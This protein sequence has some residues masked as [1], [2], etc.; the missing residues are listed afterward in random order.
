MKLAKFIF[1]F[2]VF[3][4]LILTAFTYFKSRPPKIKSNNTSPT[5]E[6]LSEREKIKYSLETP[7]SESLKGNITSM[8]GEIFWQSRVATE[9][10]KIISPRIILQGENL[11]TGAESSLSLTFEK[12]CV[13]NMEEKTAVEIIQT[14][15]ANIVFRQTSGVA[16]YSN[17][18]SFPV[19]IRTLSTLA[20]IDG[21]TE[22]SVDMDKSVVIITALSGSAII[23]YN[24][25]GYVSHQI[26]VETGQK[27]I[28][29]HATRKGALK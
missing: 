10:S 6:K 13:L 11:S 18:G 29:N 2:L 15:P 9:S 20:D 23:A 26:S 4:S 3:F 27:Y 16:Q 8:T 22:I 5:S 1:I 12:S 14:L 17:T 24:D 25:L 28:F 19:S 7:P 21:T